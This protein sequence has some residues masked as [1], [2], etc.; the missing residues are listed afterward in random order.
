ML[1]LHEFQKLII[2]ICS[3]RAVFQSLFYLL[4]NH[5]NQLEFFS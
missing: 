2:I 4:S 5:Q 1:R 3:K